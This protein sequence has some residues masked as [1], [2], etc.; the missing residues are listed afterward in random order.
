[1]TEEKGAANLGWG[2]GLVG[3]RYNPGNDGFG[4]RSQGTAREKKKNTRP[5]DGGEL[6]HKEADVAV[7]VG[8]LRKEGS[9]HG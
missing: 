5:Q 4:G 6:V 2:K 3:S 7:T 8:V 1:V 9:A